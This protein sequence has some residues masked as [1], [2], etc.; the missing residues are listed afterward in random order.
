MQTNDATNLIDNLP[1]D[2]HAEV[3]NVMTGILPAFKTTKIVETGDVTNNR[4]KGGRPKDASSKKNR[5]LSIST[6]SVANEV[7]TK[8]DT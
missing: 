6:T 4:A 2:D 7:A 5:H 1:N 8:Y 3:A